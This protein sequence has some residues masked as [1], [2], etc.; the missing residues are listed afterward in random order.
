MKRRKSPDTGFRRAR[1]LWAATSRG[2]QLEGI[3]AV[4]LLTEEDDFN[5]LGS[6]QPWGVC[7]DLPAGPGEPADAPPFTYLPP[8]GRV[9]A[10]WAEWAD[11]KGPFLPGLR[12]PT[13]T[14]RHR[15]EARAPAVHLHLQCPAPPRTF[16][17]SPG[18]RGSRR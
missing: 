12:A 10:I 17:H 11:G 5:A 9:T 14:A 16:T 4:L 8:A 7:H 18:N 6:A 13:S 15:E 3:T 1:L 2:A